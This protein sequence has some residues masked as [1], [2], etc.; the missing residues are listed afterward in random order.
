MFLFTNI[1]PPPHPPPKR[2]IRED[3]IKEDCDMYLAERIIV[4]IV[5]IAVAAFMVLSMM[6]II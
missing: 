1:P 5:G 6:G 4:A 3:L 2:Y